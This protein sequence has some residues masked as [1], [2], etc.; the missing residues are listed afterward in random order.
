VAGRPGVVPE[1]T[2]RGF[3]HGIHTI[4]VDPA[5]PWPEGY[6]VSDTWGDAFDLLN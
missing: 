2:G 4:G 6:A 3:I 1:I 5:D